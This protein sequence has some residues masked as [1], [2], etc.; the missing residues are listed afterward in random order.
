MGFNEPLAFPTFIP[1]RP[2]PE[3]CYFLC[4][5][6]LRCP[7][8]WDNARCIAL[9]WPASASALMD[10]PSNTLGSLVMDAWGR[11]PVHGCHGG[12][13]GWWVGRRVHCS[14]CGSMHARNTTARPA[15]PRCPPAAKEAEMLPHDSNLPPAVAIPVGVG[16]CKLLSCI[17]VLNRRTWRE[18]CAR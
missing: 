5:A 3:T 9:P 4:P 17:F 10:T 1:I 8:L 2:P 11:R 16:A 7:F 14:P 12:E 18:N 15:V 6:H 13:W